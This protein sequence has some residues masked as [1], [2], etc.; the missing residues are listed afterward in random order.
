MIPIRLRFLFI[1]VIGVII[2]AAVVAVELQSTP[3]CVK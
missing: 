1:F 3:E 2:G